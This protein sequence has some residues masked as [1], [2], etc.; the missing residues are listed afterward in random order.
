MTQQFYSYELKTVTQI[1]T[2]THEFTAALFITAKKG[3]KSPDNPPVDEWISKTRDI[4]IQ[5]N[6][7][8]PG[9]ELCYKMEEPQKYAGERSQTQKV[10]YSMFLFT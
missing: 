1:D 4:S 6:I 9:T 2:C 8:Q 10:T 5:W 7:T 3:A